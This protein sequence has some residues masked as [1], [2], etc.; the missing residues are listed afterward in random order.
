[1]FCQSLS[2]VR[3]MMAVAHV[4][5]AG[6]GGGEE[7]RILG[8]CRSLESLSLGGVAA[9]APHTQLPR[10]YRSALPGEKSTFQGAGV[11][12]VSRMPNGEARI[13]LWQPQSGKKKGVRWYDFGGTK[14]DKSEYTSYCACRKFAKQTYGIFGCNFEVQGMPPESIGEHLR[15]LYQGL[16]N[17]PLML[18]AS[19]EWAQMQMLN[20]SARNFYNDVHEYHVYLLGVPYISADV[21][22]RISGL[23][24]G[25]KRNFRW[26]SKEDLKEAVLAPR[27]HTHSLM[28][29]IENLAD[30]EWVRPA[31]AYGAPQMRAANGTF[32]ATALKGQK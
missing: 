32:T 16:C 11:V 12:P 31:Q 18:K 9:M 27:L 20:D 7:A 23:V 30:D 21:L 2:A 19:Q 8:A 13:L 24:D 15:E 1:M 17:L 14:L 22:T 29:Q 6:D 3:A 28:Q 26:L 4:D 10:K 5:G 25:G